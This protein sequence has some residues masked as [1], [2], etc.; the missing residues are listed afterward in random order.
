MS[1]AL[2]SHETHSFFRDDARVPKNQQ[3]AV[4]GIDLREHKK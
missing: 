1:F 2:A 4:T 3:A